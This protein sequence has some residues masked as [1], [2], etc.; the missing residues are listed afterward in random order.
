MWHRQ[1]VRALDTETIQRQ[2][3]FDSFASFASLQPSSAASNSSSRLSVRGYLSLFQLFL[4]DSSMTLDML[5]TEIVLFN[6]Q[7]R[8]DEAK[9]EDPS[10][11][12]LPSKELTRPAKAQNDHVSSIMVLPNEVHFEIIKYIA[13][14]DTVSLRSAIRFFHA[15]IPNPPIFKLLLEIRFL[16][17]RELKDGP[18]FTSL[19]ATCHNFKRPF[20]PFTRKTLAAAEDCLHAIHGTK[21]RLACYTCLQS[22]SPYHFVRW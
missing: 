4:A 5:S 14:S 3:F 6:L 11:P 10:I 17:C 12:N 8:I 19:H 16:I 21:A 15:L 18:S 22:Y 9:S 20:N 13:F 2:I 1:E 7:N